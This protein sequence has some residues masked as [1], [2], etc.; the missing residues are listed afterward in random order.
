MYRAT[1]RNIR[2]TVTPDYSAERSSPKERRYFWTYTIEIANLGGE[3]VQLMSRHWRITD[4]RGHTEEV[5]GPG[6]VGEQPVLGPNQRFEYTSCV[7]LSTTSGVMAGSYQMVTEE[8]AAFDAEVP[9]FSLD[10]PEA[11]RVVH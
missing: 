4:A 11:P 1:T 5:R 8:G 9:A 7:P 3:T 2:I 6:V 10:A